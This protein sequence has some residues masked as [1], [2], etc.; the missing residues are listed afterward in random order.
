VQ[1][2]GDAVDRLRCCMPNHTTLTVPRQ[3]AVASATV[4]IPPA[5]QATKP[6]AALK[7]QSC[8]LRSGRP[9]EFQWSAQPES[10][11]RCRQATGG[12]A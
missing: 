9:V 2:I 1:W 8:P 3:V 7:Y 4:T 5:T 11:P 6:D 10:R 12:F